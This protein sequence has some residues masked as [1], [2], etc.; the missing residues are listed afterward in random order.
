MLL[1][2]YLLR[3]GRGGY[4]REFTF[5]KLTILTKPYLALRV[6]IPNIHSQTNNTNKETK[7]LNTN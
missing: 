4:C 6:S 3:V 5:G 1:K 7:T 2:D